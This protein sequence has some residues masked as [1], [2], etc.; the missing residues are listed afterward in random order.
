MIHRWLISL[1]MASP[2]YGMD[3]GALITSVIT[4]MQ[5][6]PS[7]KVCVALPSRCD[8][9]QEALDKGNHIR[10]G[11][12]LRYT[13]ETEW[14]SYEINGYS[15]LQ[16]AVKLAEFSYEKKMGAT[17]EKVIV[18]RIDEAVE[19]NRLA[20]VG[21]LLIFGA[22]RNE[23][24]GA[25]ENEMAIQCKHPGLQALFKI[26][27][28][29]QNNQPQPQVMDR[30]L[31]FLGSLGVQSNQPPE[32]DPSKS[33]PE[34]PSPESQSSQEAEVS[35]PSWPIRKWMVSAA[36]FIGLTFLTNA[37]S[38][39]IKKVEKEKEEKKTKK[40]ESAPQT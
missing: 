3:S 37:L 9:F 35:R 20:C 26:C 33:T 27:A 5:E 17:G 32:P 10:L 16:Y 12:L 11:Y 36:A 13:R 1:L 18:K 6:V 24:G 19:Y 7:R 2:L 4:P 39:Y 23:T 14:R 28:S 21:I 38:T 8:E 34:G 31:V 30:P 29:E 22:D 15:L 40:E 25:K